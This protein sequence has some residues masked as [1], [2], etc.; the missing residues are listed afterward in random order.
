M[1]KYFLT[2]ATVALFAVGFAASDEEESSSSSS[3]G[4]SKPQTEQKQE[5]K[6]ETEAERKAKEKAEKRKDLLEHARYWANKLSSFQ[7]DE[8]DD[9]S[10]SY[11]DGKC[12]ESFMEKIPN[13]TTDEDFEL[14]REFKEVW[15]EE[16][17]KVQAAK[18]RMDN[19]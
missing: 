6:K 19:I 14:Y 11:R 12:K 8:D 1:K 10:R 18:Q 17:D 7:D 9:D 16:W 5:Q 3:I 4:S 2:M 13:P 15:D